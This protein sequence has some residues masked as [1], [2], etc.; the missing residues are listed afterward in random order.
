[1]AKGIALI[2]SHKNNKTTSKKITVN[3]DEN[4]SNKKWIKKNETTSFHKIDGIAT[5]CVCAPLNDP[6]NPH[7]IFELLVCHRYKRGLQVE[8]CKSTILN[9][10]TNIGITSIMSN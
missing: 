5:P 1:M 2:R 3:I 4:I 7:K 8:F 6:S 10:L 9:E